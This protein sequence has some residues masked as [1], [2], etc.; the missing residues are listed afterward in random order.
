MCCSNSYP[1]QASGGGGGYGGGG[2]GG[3]G[4]QPRA[5]QNPYAQQDDRAYEMSDVKDNSVPLAPMGG[6][7]DSMSTF[8]TEASY[9]LIQC[10]DITNGGPA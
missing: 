4:Y 7:G 8:Y 9:V 10:G 1:T 6:G 3:G 5:R 2:G